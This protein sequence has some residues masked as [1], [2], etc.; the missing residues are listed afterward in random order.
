MITMCKHLRSLED[1]TSMEDGADL[2]L[3]APEGRARTNGFK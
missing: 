1:E 3:V 2:F